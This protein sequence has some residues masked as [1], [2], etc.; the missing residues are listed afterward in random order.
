MNESARETHVIISPHFDDGI[1]TCGGTAH[2]LSAAGHAVIVMTIMGGL[3]DG[4]LPKTPILADLHRRWE[5]GE[6]P[7]RRRQLEDEQA[8]RV[9]GVDFMHVPLPDCVYRVAGDLALYP[10]EESL[11]ADVHPADYAP[12][13]LQGIQIPELE[14][15]ASVHLPLGVG[16][17]VDHQIARDWGM[18][19]ARDVPDKGALRFYAEFPYSNADRSTEI[20]LAEFGMALEPAD[21]VLSEADMRAKIQAIAC[22]QSQI[23]T[24]WDSLEAMEADVRRAFRDEASGSYVERFWTIAGG[25]KLAES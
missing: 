12:R 8:S 21:I 2:Q 3:Y 23:S 9:I 17:H 24:F 22:Y 10:S 25:I 1:F 19:Q 7:L 13:L 11:F 4:E 6:N 5:A 18:T 15:A 16:H 20:A 14:T